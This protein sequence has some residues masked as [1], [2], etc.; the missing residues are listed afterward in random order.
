MKISSNE[1]YTGGSYLEHNQN[2]NLEDA[3]WKAAIIHKLLKRNNILPADIVDVGCGAG[4]VLEEL[5]KKDLG[6]KT[7]T[8]FDIAPDAIAIACK[9][10]TGNVQFI[11]D[12]YT[13]DG[14]PQTNLL[15]AIDVIEHIDDFYGFL[16]K[17]KA[18]SEYFIFHIPLDLC[19]WSLLRPHIL[20]QQRNAVGH[21]HYFSKEMVLWF[22][23]DIGFTVI[24]FEYSKPDLD[25]KPAATFKLFVKKQLRKI[26]FAINKEL[27]IK[28][29]GGYSM[30]ILLK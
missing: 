10:G 1:F 23:A 22:L 20:L 28:L 21:I 11:N 13:K 29:W 14:Y 26:S 17:L 3:S 30:M 5:A 6:T 7:F 12:D 4:G 25:I 19:C 8:G 9:K 2:W 18:R 27:S 16:R 24:D 15:L